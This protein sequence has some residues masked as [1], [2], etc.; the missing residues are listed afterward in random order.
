MVKM[1]RKT[2]AVG[3]TG[4]CAF[5]SLYATQPLLP[6]FQ[7]AFQASKLGVSLTV[8][9]A[10]LAVALVAPWSGVVA[11][12]LGR[13]RV[14]VPAVFVLGLTNLLTASSTGLA[15]LVAWRFVQGV[16]TPAVFAV[17]VAYISEEWPLG[18]VAFAT[19][20]YVTGT[21]LGGFTGRFLSGLIAV[22]FS[23]RWAFVAL[24]LLN[25]GLGVAVA[26]WM[27]LA[28]RFNRHEGYFQSARA[29]VGH[30]AN[31]DLWAVFAVGF[32][33]LFS[34]VGTF[35]YVTFHLA[36]PPYKLS[37]SKLGSIFFVYLIGAVITPLVGHFGDRIKGRVT[38]AS[39]L[40]TSAFGVLLTLASPLWV[41]MLGITLCASGVFV[42]QI[43]T[44]RAVGLR[45]KGSRAAAVGLYVTCYYLGGFVGSVAPGLLWAWGGWPA[46][47]ALIGG[48]LVTASLYVAITWRDAAGLT[49]V[50]P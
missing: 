4:F 11:D 9:A 32:C 14:I 44:N 15:S 5:L 46:C 37:T 26:A 12:V 16:F 7:R 29:M 39:A 28:K 25:L 8:S 30:L 6:L 2:W 49:T 40:A 23:W 19:S 21:V 24:G 18:Q 48:V 38:L 13:K 33:I 17:T 47:V 43:V 31:R 20:V 34:L 36:A 3:M 1:D 42:C 22:D 50:T 10:T 27:P 45:S 41:V 35:T